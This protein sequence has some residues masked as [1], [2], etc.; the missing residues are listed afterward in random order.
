M[1]NA[2]KAHWMYTK[3]VDKYDKIVDKGKRV[4]RNIYAH[5]EQSTKYTEEFKKT[6]VSLYQSGKTY[7]QIQKEYGVFS[8]RKRGMTEIMSRA[9]NH[10]NLFYWTLLPGVGLDQPQRA[11]SMGTICFFRDMIFGRKML[12]WLAPEPKA[13]CTALVSPR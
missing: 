5:K 11:E 9:K 6:I 12:S 2:R 1:E 8:K 13:C 3:K 10:V 7:S 4:K